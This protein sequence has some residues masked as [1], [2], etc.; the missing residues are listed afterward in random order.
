MHLTAIWSFLHGKKRPL[1]KMLRIMKLTAI[2]LLCACLQ[3][4]AKTSGQGVTLSVKDAPIKEVF[5]EIQK[6]TGTNVLV[7][8]K[9]LARAGKVTLN[10]QN[11]PVD[12]VLNL[13]FQNANLTY[14]IIDGTIVVRPKRMVTIQPSDNLRSV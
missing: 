2:F 12:Q 9:V 7:N 4:A 13:C 8:E 11:M 3:L 1:T 10:V 6:Q 14:S 5:R